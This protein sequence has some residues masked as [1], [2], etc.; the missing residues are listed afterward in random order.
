LD[1]VILVLKKKQL[2]FLHVYH[3]TIVLPMSFLW[4]DAHMIFHAFG[5]VF[6]TSIHVIMYY[7][8]GRSA[9]GRKVIPAAEAS[10]DRENPKRLVVKG[11][12]KRYPHFEKVYAYNHEGLHEDQQVIGYAVQTYAPFWKRYLTS[13]Q[14]TQ[15]AT[16]F[17]LTGIFLYYYFYDGPCSG[18][19][20]LCFTMFCNSTFLVL[21]SNFYKKSYSIA[22]SAASKKSSRSSAIKTE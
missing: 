22:S 4:L 2:I 5:L 10:I 9:L 20:A 1:T 13:M 12:G 7:Y 6:N 8:Y 17:V 18:G 19:L 15:F 21:F 3:H 11:T 14:I 16:S